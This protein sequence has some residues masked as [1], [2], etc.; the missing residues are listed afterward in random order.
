MTPDRA[1]APAPGRA[2]A[3]DLRPAAPDPGPAGPARGRAPASRAARFLALDLGRDFALLCGGQAVSQ[4]GSRGYGVAVMLWI[5]ASTGSPAVVGLVASFTLGVVAAASVPAGWVA[6]RFDRRRVMVVCDGL[7]AVAVGSLAVAPFRLAHVLP[8]VAVLAVG[9]VVRGTAESAA[10]PNVVE[11]GQLPRAIALAH[12]R[13]YAAGVAGP[14]LAGVLF[15][16]DPVLPFVV[17]ACSYLVAGVCAALV[18]RPLRSAGPPRGVPAPAE[19]LRTVWRHPFLRGSTLVAAL[20]D[21]VVNSGGLVLVVVLERHGLPPQA[22]GSALA[23]AYA[24]G[25]LGT[26]AAQRAGRRL[27]SRRLVVTGL[28]AGTA[29]TAVLAASLPVAACAGYAC[30]MLA[31]PVWQ[32]PLQ[33][34]WTRM[35]GDEMRGRVNGTISLVM[36]VPA[37]TAPATVGL[38]TAALGTGPTGLLLAAVIGA[39]GL[40]FAARDRRTPVRAST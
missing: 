13:G 32:I 6:D 30:L 2:S 28:A 40:A 23:L 16:V 12:G 8:A 29:A 17:D 26:V 25:L 1:P 4:L 11:D 14:A 31:R 3:P 21:F 35:V 7:S 37:A 34:D 33:T 36:T 10:I 15:A 9:W 22:T 27:P 18:R 5:L 38:L 19:G 24:A 20:A 39:A